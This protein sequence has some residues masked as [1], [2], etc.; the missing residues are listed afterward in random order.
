MLAVAVL[1]VIAVAGIV[2]ATLRR[3]PSVDAPVAADSTRPASAPM[4]A[5][6]TAASATAAEAEAAPNQV[7]FTAGSD[8][9][10]DAATVKLVRIAATAVKD[11]RELVIA[12]KIEA[13]PDRNQRMELARNRAFAVRAVLEANGVPM[14]RMQIQIAE[15]PLG[16]VSVNDANR[17]EVSPR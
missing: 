6:A 11:K 17:V 3:D 13:R 4:T 10:S 12:G 1:V 7:V 2:L 14:T 15:L 9:V 5:A 16:L 8:Q